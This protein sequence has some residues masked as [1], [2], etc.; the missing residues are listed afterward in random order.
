MGGAA[1]QA[2]DADVHAADVSIAMGRGPYY[3]RFVLTQPDHGQQRKIISNRAEV[4]ESCQQISLESIERPRLAKRREG[5]M[6]GYGLEDLSYVNA[7]TP[8]AYLADGSRQNSLWIWE[9][10]RL[11]RARREPDGVR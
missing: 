3:A 4:S 5:L 7:S 10:L 11:R 8:S 2:F 9:S 1:E 6:L